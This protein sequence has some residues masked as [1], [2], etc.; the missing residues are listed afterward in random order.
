MGCAIGILVWVGG[1]KA[2][3]VVSA[4]L[5]GQSGGERVSCEGRDTLG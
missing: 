3:L 1:N 4:P 2:E 5:A